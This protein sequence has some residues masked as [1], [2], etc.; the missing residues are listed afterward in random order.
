MRTAEKKAPTAAAPVLPDSEHRVLSFRLDN[1]LR[2]IVIP[3]PHLH[4]AAL[5]ATVHVGSRHEDASSSGLSHLL[6]HMLFRGTSSYPTAHDLNLAIEQLGGSGWGVTYSDHTLF[7]LTLPPENAEAGL[8][9]FS[10]LFLCP[11]FEDLEVEKRIVREEILQSLDENGRNVDVDDLGRKLLFGSH[12]L[13][14]TIGGSASNVDRF[15]AADLQQHR[16]RYYVAENMVL[17]AAGAVDPDRLLGE[18]NRAFASLPRGRRVETSA[19]GTFEKGPRLRLVES[20]GSQSDVRIF[21]HAPGETDPG[22][23]ALQLL[24]RVIDDG[25]STRLQRRIV[26]ELGLAYDVFAVLEPYQEC[27]VFGVG[28]TAEHG[29]VPRLVKET[30]KLLWEMTQREVSAPELD[31]ARQRYRWSLRASLDNAE[32]MCSHYGAMAL[33]DLDGHL[34]RLAESA[35]RVTAADLRET[36]LRIIRPEGLQVA[37]VGTLDRRMARQTREATYAFGSAG[38]R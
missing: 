34:Q 23:M 32:S 33:F 14:F 6:E 35:I 2:F 15:G 25:M 4:S 19:P 16:E 22:R 38:D 1:G 28:A 26:D 17:C 9:V 11:R 12:P 27:G 24:T 8:R 13:G 36:A 29:K 5:T 21:F 20:P 3:M 31:K 37:C 30:L 10:E 18:A 7:G